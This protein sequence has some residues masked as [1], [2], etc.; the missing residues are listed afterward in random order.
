[1]Y[2]ET[3][4]QLIEMDG[5]GVFVWAAYAVTLV[6]IT[7]LFVVPAMKH[8]R[9]KRELRQRIVRRQTHAQQAGDSE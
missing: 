6:V 7:A 5:H 9:I 2:F 1:M 4:S 8:T 3:L